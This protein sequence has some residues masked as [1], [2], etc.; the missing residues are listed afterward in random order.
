MA[1]VSIEE[2]RSDAARMTA[3]RQHRFLLLIAGV[4]MISFLMVLIGMYLYNTSGA[5]QVDLSRPGYQS[6]QREASRDTTDDSFAST[7]KLDKDA[8]DSFDKMYANHA[9]QVVGVDSFDPGA[10]DPNT[11]LP[12][13]NSGQA[14]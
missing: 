3:W 9:R 11:L 7:G 5:A 8:F 10:I 6:I 13:I 12:G 14:Q 1:V 4:I 2:L